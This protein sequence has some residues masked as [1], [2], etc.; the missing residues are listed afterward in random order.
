MN[1]FIW[2]VIIAIIA[3]IGVFANPNEPPEQ[4]HPSASCCTPHVS[5]YSISNDEVTI[6]TSG[7]RINIAV[8]DDI[9][10]NDLSIFNDRQASKT[11]LIG[12]QLMVMSSM[13]FDNNMTYIYYNYDQDDFFVGGAGKNQLG[14]IRFENVDGTAEDITTFMWNGNHWTSTSDHF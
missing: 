3:M 7:A 2:I 6:M 12:D 4:I 5:H 13:I 10:T 14:V 9:V 11:P 1:S 8:I